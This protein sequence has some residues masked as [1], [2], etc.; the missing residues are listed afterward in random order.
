MRTTAN[1]ILGVTAILLVALTAWS[2]ISP[3]A[4]TEL[5][6]SLNQVVQ[7]LMIAATA[8]FGFS[9]ATRADVPLFLRRAIDTAGIGRRHAPLHRR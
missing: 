6:L 3:F 8:G 2:F 5:A 4:E 9:I 7:F 1:R